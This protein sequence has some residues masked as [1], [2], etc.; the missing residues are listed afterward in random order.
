MKIGFLTPYK[1]LPNFKAFVEEKFECIDISK[2]VI[3]VD[4]IFSAPNYRNCVVTNE[5]V[6]KAKTIDILSP[7]TGTN[8]ITADSVNVTSIKNDD[9]L[10]DISSTAEHNLYL[11]LCLT[12]N[13]EPLKQLSDLTLG[14]LGYGRL[15]QL[16]E[17]RTKKLYKSVLAKDIDFEDPEFF[18]DTDILSINIDLQDSNI[19]LIN[20]EYISKFKKPIYIVNTSRG[21]VVN[22][23]DILDSLYSNKVLGYATDVIQHEHNS[24]VTP[25][26]VEKHRNLII[27]PHVGG[28]AIGA[29]ERAYK[30]VIE[31]III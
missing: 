31:K 27:T 11:T 30:R 5:I 15:G 25:L 24:K 18:E 17:T 6:K 8:H 3:P 20:K 14:I 12:R 2:K 1:H 28:T 9:V 26:K 16:L 4:Y 19:E 21:E 22:E 29:Q 7:S 13:I 23:N 10:W